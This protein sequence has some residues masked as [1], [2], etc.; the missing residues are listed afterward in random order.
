MSDPEFRK[1]CLKFIEKLGSDFPSR[2]E[3]SLGQDFEKAVEM[4]PKEVLTRILQDVY[5]RYVCPYEM[6]INVS[7]YLQENFDIRDFSLSLSEKYDF[8]MSEKVQEG[9]L[10][11]D[12]FYDM[13]KTLGL[14][15]VINSQKQKRWENE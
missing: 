7:N 3:R 8:P 13:L 2:I 6:A 10:F 9:K 14:E 1:I 11:V 12:K 15:E 4:R 5:I